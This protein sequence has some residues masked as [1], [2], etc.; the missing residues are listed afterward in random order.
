M[1]GEHLISLEEFWSEEEEF[2]AIFE[3]FGFA[4]YSAQ[5]LENRMA[6]L[7]GL[8]LV[9]SR[10]YTDLESARTSIKEKTEITMGSL[11]REL[12]G[13]L[14]D[15]HLYTLLG[16]ARTKRN[17]LIHQFFRVHEFDDETQRGRLEMI[18]EC[19][20]YSD[21]F[22][23]ISTHSLMPRIMKVL[24]Q[25]EADPDHFVSG[26]TDQIEREFSKLRASH[27]P[28]QTDNLPT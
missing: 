13:F 26:L 23:D 16:A 1:E 17:H 6:M 12:E 10:T 21:Y 25:I 2:A 3:E 20:E 14:D 5:R 28:G 15:D 7:L 11:L 18:R 19:R 8:S 4:G 22:N 24:N 27:A 9:A